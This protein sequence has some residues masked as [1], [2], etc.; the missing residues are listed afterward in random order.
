MST[1]YLT[2]NGH[3]LYVEQKGPPDGFPV[4]LL[5]H[6]LGSTHAWRLQVTALSEAGYCAVAYDRWG[7]GR[8]DPRAQLSMPYFLEDQDDL[9]AL[10]DQSQNERAVLVGHSDGG[11]IALYFAANHPQRVS[12]LVTLAA[13]AYVEEKMIAALPHVLRQYSEDADFRVRLQRR[14]GNKAE[15]IVTGWYNGW[16]QDTNLGW[17]MRPVLAQIRCPVLVMQGEA[18]EHATPRHA[19]EIANAIP[20]ADLA[21]LPGAHHMLQ[22]E[23][24]DEVNRRLLEF[25]GQVVKQEFADV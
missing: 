13:H 19:Q 10:L 5:H 20:C 21:L 9:L 25:L 4:I 8:S 7:Y 12:C 24:A 15:T 22:R 3:A 17:D 1:G 23:Q 16:N 6:G 2:A 18:D 14:H 11:T